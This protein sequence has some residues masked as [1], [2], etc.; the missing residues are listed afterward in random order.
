[1][2]NYIHADLNRIFHRISRWVIIVLFLA[3]GLGFE[4]YQAVTRSYN[5]INLTSA[6]YTFFDLAA[7]VLG[8]V[9]IQSVFADDFRAKTMQIAIG[10]G[11]SRPKIV[12]AKLLDFAILALI[13]SLTIM[14][15]YTLGGTA[16]GIHLMGEQIYLMFISALESAVLMTIVAAITMIPVFYMQSTTFAVLFF[17]IISLD[18]LK[19]VFQLLSTKEIVLNLHL[20]ELMFSSVNNTLF[21]QLSLRNMFPIAQFL[22][23]IA[24]LAAAYG[25]SVLAFRKREL[26]F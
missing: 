13:D 10:L 26:E 22:G 9:E 24:Y 18:P 21:T 19:M 7:V 4:F 12:L 6:A 15:L 11:V 17:L 1:M 16:C 5:G 2:T 20:V 3:G 8:I 23:V 25:L 14:V